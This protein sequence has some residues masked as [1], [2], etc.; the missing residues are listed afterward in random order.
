MYIHEAEMNQTNLLENMVKCNNKSRPKT[1][2]GKD[3]KRNTFDSVSALY[4][5]RELTLNVFINGIF[6]VKEKQ[7]KGLKI[8]TP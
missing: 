7:E 8:L 5:G 2:E 6:P 4:E 1:K 3:E